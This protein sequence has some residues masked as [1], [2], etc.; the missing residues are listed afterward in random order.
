MIQGPVARGRA[1]IDIATVRRGGASSRPPCRG[2]GSPESTS[3]STS[4]PPTALRLNR[5][6]RGS[7]TDITPQSTRVNWASGDRAPRHEAGDRSNQLAD[8][9]AA[10]EQ[11]M[12]TVGRVVHHRVLHVDAELVIERGEHFLI[13]NRAVLRFFAQAVG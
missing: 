7:R 4:S 13:M 12:R 5:R 6:I 9:L 3:G 1:R 11:E 8:G 10:I 2:P